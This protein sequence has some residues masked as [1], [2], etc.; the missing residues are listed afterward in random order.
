[1]NARH[2]RW[3]DYLQ[4]FEFVIR[5]KLGT[6]N[7]VADALS[8]RP[9]LLPIFPATVTGFES[10]KT[11]YINDEDFGSVCKSISDQGHTA[12]KDYVL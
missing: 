11:E 8:R 10:M 5:H 1:M 9:H 7:K 12:R 6:K 4:Q 2:A 3:V